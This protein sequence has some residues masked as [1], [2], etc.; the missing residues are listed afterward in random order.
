MNEFPHYQHVALPELIQQALPFGPVPAAARRL[1]A[2]NAL[3][4]RRLQRAT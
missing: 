1:L 3:T 4:F 2:I